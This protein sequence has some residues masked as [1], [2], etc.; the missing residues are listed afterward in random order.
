MTLS[1][2]NTIVVASAGSRKTT[3]LVEQALLRKTE[4]I[5]IT[6][7]TNENIDQIRA[8]F[9]SAVGSVPANVTIV[10]WF[11]FLLADGVRPYQN[12]VSE[13]GRVQNILFGDL[14]DFARFVK[15]SNIDGYFFTTGGLIFQDRVSEFVCFCDDHTNG[16]I[17]QRLC[18]LYDTIFIDEIQDLAGYD[19]Q[20][21]EKLLHS[22]LRFIGVGDPRQATY[23]TNRNK[24]NSAF[25]RGDIFEWIAKMAGKEVTLEH[26]VE[27]F[28]SNQRICDFADALFP[29]H[30]KTVSKNATETGHDGIF[31][32]KRDQ[33]SEYIRER[34][35]AILRYDRR[36]NTMGYSATNIGSVKGRTFDRVLI[37]PTKPMKEYFK[38]R[39]LSKAGSL[40][41]LYVAVTRAR[42]S[43]AFVL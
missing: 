16:K 33:V 28:R 40:E 30:P 13:S 35:P 34:N 11:S 10:S 3:S 14:P 23:S 37:F 4:R 2:K 19:L 29:S 9:V 36:T 39:D 38:T 8:Y 22:P 25:K 24:K 5:L 26:R 17:V 20:F 41:K 18:R 31:G 21:L 6:T 43:V 7:Y 42:F 27:C 32:I 12:L 1:L 15:K